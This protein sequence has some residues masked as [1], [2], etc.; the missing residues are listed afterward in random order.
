MSAQSI[1]IRK[2]AV[3]VLVVLVV[4]LAVVVLVPAPEALAHGCGTSDHGYGPWYY[5]EMHYYWGQ[6]ISGGALIVK[7]RVVSPGGIYYTES[8]C[9]CVTYPCNY[10][11]VPLPSE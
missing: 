8:W 11:P 3:L 7:W 10:A 6:Y 2:V 4:V 9:G 5:F 1:P